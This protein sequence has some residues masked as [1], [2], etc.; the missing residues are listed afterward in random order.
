MPLGTHHSGVFEG[1]A[2]EIVAHDPRSDR[3]F[4]TNA[5]TGNLDILQLNPTGTLSLIG[6]V[7]TIGAASHVRIW[8]NGTTSFV[9]AAVPAANLANP[10]SV[11][12]FTT[13]GVLQ[14]THVVGA[15][16]DMLYVTSNHLALTANEGQPIGAANPPGSVSIVNLQTGFV[17]TVSFAVFNGQE[18]ALRNAGVRIF[19]GLSA[20]IDL[21]PEYIAVT[22]DNTTAYAVCQEQN[23]VV[24]IDIPTA[25]ATSIHTL[26]TKD[27]SIVGNGL[28]GSDS[29]GGINISNWPVHGMYMPDSSVTYQ[30]NGQNYLLTANEGDARNEAGRARTLNLDPVTFPNAAFLQQNGNMGRLFVSTID[31]DLDGDGDFDEVYCYGSRSFSIFNMSAGAELVYDSGDEFAVTIAALETENFNSNSTSNNSADGRSDNKGCEPEAVVVAQIGDRNLAFIGMERQGGIFA[32]DVTTPASSQLLGYFSNRNFG[33]NIESQAAGDLG[34]ESIV[35]VKPEDNALGQP[36]LITGNE[37]S[38]TTTVFLIL[39]AFPTPDCNGNSVPDP[40]DL[41]SGTSE[42]CNGDGIPDECQISED[43]C[44]LNGLLDFCE[45]ATGAALDCNGNAIP[46]SCDLASGDVDCDG[47]SVPDSCDLAAGAVDGN[48]DGILDRCQGVP[49]ISGDGNQ[50]GV[51]DITDAVQILSVLFGN[52][53]SVCPYSLDTNGSGTADISDVVYLLDYIFQGGLAPAAPFPSCGIR[54]GILGGC[55]SFS[56]CP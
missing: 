34:V 6:F 12:V 22:P 37:I 47:N 20:S 52:V 55:D 45:I 30:V 33:A 19:P 32:Y 43:D 42:D 28:D 23:S 36:L 24:V 41:A 51:I 3:I 49:F 29:D 48:L 10:G 8:D 27:H 46:D 18:A 17:S 56:N 21:E 31:G 14:A 5:S 1:S 2:S 53:I 44:N 4:V 40:D 15:L 54:V 26:G 9:V 7:N 16:P 13:S 38:G 39:G 35:Y 11:Q 25:T 50:D